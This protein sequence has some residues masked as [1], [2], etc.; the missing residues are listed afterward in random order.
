[1]APARSGP[2]GAK[3]APF[4]TPFP[5]PQRTLDLRREDVYLRIRLCVLRFP[6]CVLAR[7]LGKHCRN[8]FFARRTAF[9]SRA[10]QTHPEFPTTKAS[11]TA[12]LPH[13]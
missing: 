2:N 9:Q 13:R 1:M 7:W 6:C 3:Q 11:F 10:H 8:V 12:T 5:A 4:R